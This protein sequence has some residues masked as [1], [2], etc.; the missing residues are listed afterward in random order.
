MRF[1][2]ANCSKETNPRNLGNFHN[3]TFANLPQGWLGRSEWDHLTNRDIV[4]VIVCG[5]E[6]A[7]EYRNQEFE[8]AQKTCKHDKG[9]YYVGSARSFFYRCSNCN[10]PGRLEKPPKGEEY[11]HPD[12]TIDKNV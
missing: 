1:R 4:T 7:E 2:C 10:I 12:P 8:E 3:K 5:K 11:F 6:C 9:H